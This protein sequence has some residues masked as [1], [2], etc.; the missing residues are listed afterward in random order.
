MHGLPVLS[1]VLLCISKGSTPAGCA[2]SHQVDKGIHQ[3]EA[4]MGGFGTEERSQSISLAS[5]Y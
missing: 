1:V 4:K 5:L 2:Y 3:W